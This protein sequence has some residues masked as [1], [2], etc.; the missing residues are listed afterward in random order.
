LLV[1]ETADLA[2]DLVALELR[3]RGAEYRRFNQDR[4]RDSVEMAIRPGG[5]A[6]FWTPGWE[7]SSTEV[8]GAWYR[9]PPRACHPEPYVDA[10]ARA[11]L[12][13][14]WAETGWSWIN[15]P[16]APARAGDKL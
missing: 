15:E 11:L 6:I 14:V 2:A 12:A 4:F 3:H 1:T 8:G 13:A 5:S 9:S 16:G 10:E 7:L